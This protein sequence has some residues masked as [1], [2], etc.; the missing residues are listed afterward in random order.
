MTPTSVDTPLLI[1]QAIFDGA[2]L[3]ALRALGLLDAEAEEE[4]DRYTR[5]ATELLEVP[6]SLV[7][8]VDAHRQ[9]FISQSGLSGEIAEARQTPLS[10]SF[11]QY[12]TAS[13]EPLVVADAREHPLVKRNLAVRDL[14]V[15][16][17]A[18]IPLVLGD[19]HAVGA[20]CAVDAKPRE[21]SDKDLRILADLAAAVTAHLDL[22]KALAD[23]SLRDQT[24][25]LPNRAL[26]CAQAEQ[27]LE[28]S[29]PAAASSVGAICLGLDGFGL[30]N[31]AYGASTADRVLEAVGKRL[32]AETRAGDMLG[33]LRG[34]VFAIVSP[35]MADEKAAIQLA[36]RLRSAVAAAPFEV[37]GQQVAVTATAGLA[38]GGTAG[39]GADLLVRS[40]DSMRRGKAGGGAVRSVGSGP[41]ERAVARL[42]LRAALAGALSRGELHLA[43]QPIVALQDGA[44]VAFEA[45]VRWTSPEL[46]E[47]SPAEFI[48]LAERSGD[49]VEIGEWVLRTACAQLALWR[50]EQ[51]DLSMSVNLAPLQLELPN[52]Q[53]VV[54]SALAEQGLPASALVLELTEGALIEAGALQTKNIQLL[55]ELGVQVALD[56]FGTGYSA[57]GYLKRFPIDKLKIDRS[58]ITGLE[59]D[60]Q[61]AA[62]V[63]AI[64][65][66]ARGLDLE[67]VGEGIETAG[68]RQV[69][70]LL[71]C[72]LGQGYLFGRPASATD[73][74]LT[75][76][77][78]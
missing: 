3:A 31:E 43:Y 21:W 22:R 19:G 64:L 32:A 51:A 60:R 57:L 56:D 4:F 6:V 50:R 70:T 14:D 49:I 44:P 78:D 52:L 9:F 24:T 76:P 27:L 55:R 11:C 39:G 36:G 40:E 45:L 53:K 29:G 59:S 18:G 16:A 12:A 2:R 30:V 58:F 26:L 77:A 15:I 62:V 75:A 5:L 25:G 72:P 61:D 46:G 71:G 41:A 28:A 67:V 68:Q 13:Q 54:A 1:D 47:V 69:L 10:H 37:A 20:F 23:Q 66:L 73:I 48:P 35:D 63:Q 8:L 7:S 17:Y 74:S 34:D 42:Q 65:A 33:R 38:T